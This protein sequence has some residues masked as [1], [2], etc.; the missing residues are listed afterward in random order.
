MLTGQAHTFTATLKHI[1]PKPKYNNDKTLFELLM[2]TLK[3]TT[4]MKCQLTGD[5]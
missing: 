4:N 3:L 2:Q 5:P 1:S